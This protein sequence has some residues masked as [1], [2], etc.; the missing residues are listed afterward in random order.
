MQVGSHRKK[1]WPRRTPSIFQG[2]YALTRGLW[3]SIALAVPCFGGW[4]VS[5]FGGPLH[6]Y[7]WWAAVDTIA[8]CRG[9]AT[10]TI[11]LVSDSTEADASPRLRWDRLSSCPHLEWCQISPRL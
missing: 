6:A 7:H 10:I 4:A 11:R 2:M 8:F 5:V 9:M 1:L 3:L